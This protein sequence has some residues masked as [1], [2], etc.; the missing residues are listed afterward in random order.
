MT[1]RLAAPSVTPISETL[2]LFNAKVF[3][4]CRTAAFPSRNVGRRERNAARHEG[5]AR[6]SRP[7][8]RGCRRSG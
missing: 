2:A 8:R 7:G 4:F 3:F 5:A 6:H 1:F